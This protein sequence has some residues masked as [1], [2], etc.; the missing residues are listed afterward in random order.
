MLAHLR[1]AELVVPLV[2][3]IAIRGGITV[4]PHTLVFSLQ[5]EAWPSYEPISSFNKLFDHTQL[6]LILVTVISS[7]YDNI[8]RFQIKGLALVV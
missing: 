1:S 7:D 2:N 8:T 5:H 4:A 6:P 3:H